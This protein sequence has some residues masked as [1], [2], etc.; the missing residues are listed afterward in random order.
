VALWLV[1][2][3]EAV[4]GRF[5]DAGLSERG[6]RQARALAARLAA[7]EF[8]AALVSPLTRAGETARILLEGREVP[9]TVE[10]LLAE[11][12]V[13]DLEGLTREEARAR[14][15]DDFRFGFGVVERVAASGRTAPGGETRDA[16]VT[17]ARRAA[18]RVSR[19]YDAGGHLLVVSHGGLLNYLLQFALDLPLRDRVPFGFVNC[20][21]AALDRRDGTPPFGPFQMLHFGLLEYLD[22][23]D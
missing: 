22:G 3:A 1:R 12:S 10:P 4:S 18:E 21:V 16:F 6:R 23:I 9:T 19:E 17:R 11:G 14:Y 20:G 15:P 2:H 7:L 8:R 13:G 5:G